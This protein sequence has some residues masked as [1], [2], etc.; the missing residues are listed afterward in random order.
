MVG[1]KGEENTAGK[2]SEAEEQ[3]RRVVRERKNEDGDASGDEQIAPNG[4]QRREH[5]PYGIER[6]NPIYHLAFGEEQEV[7]KRRK[8]EC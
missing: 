1:G 6:R 4:L 2:V 7:L 5:H 3:Y 8:R